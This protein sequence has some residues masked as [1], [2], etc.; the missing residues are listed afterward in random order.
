MLAR[1]VSS[2]IGHTPG[3]EPIAT[4]D[5]TIHTLSHGTEKWPIVKK[6]DLSHLD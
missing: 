6:S 1:N 4:F 5:D 2:A 3:L